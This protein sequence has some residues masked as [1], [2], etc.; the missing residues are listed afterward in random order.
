MG[1]DG[2][3]A[4]QRREPLHRTALRLAKL[5]AADRGLVALATLFGVCLLLARLL[6]KLLSASCM[7]GGC[8]SPLQQQ[9]EHPSSAVCVASLLGLCMFALI[10]T[11]P[12]HHYTLRRT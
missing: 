7:L 3:E 9:L 11:K 10:S 8:A 4:T 12:R 1:K 2:T 5:I 6:L